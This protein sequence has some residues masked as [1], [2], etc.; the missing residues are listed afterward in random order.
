MQKR[1]SSYFMEAAVIGSGL[2]ERVGQVTRAII[3][4][5]QLAYKIELVYLEG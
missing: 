1:S 2:D 4:T 5:F 3:G